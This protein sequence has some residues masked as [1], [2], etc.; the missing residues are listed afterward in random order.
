MTTE[1]TKKRLGPRGPGRF[2]CEV[3]PQY[4]EDIGVVATLVQTP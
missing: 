2:F 4:R 1:Y 3:A